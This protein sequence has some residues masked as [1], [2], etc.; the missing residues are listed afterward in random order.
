MR[1]F[2]KDDRYSVTVSTGESLALEM[3]VFD[4]ALQMFG[5]RH[6]S[7]VMAPHGG[8]EFVTSD[9]PL[10]VVF[11]DSKARGP[12]GY[13]LPGTEV[14]FPVGARHVLLGVFE[15]PLARQIDATA[16][17]VAAINSRTVHHADRQ[18]YSR[19]EA[20]TI[21]RNDGIGNLDLERSNKRM[22]PT[23]RREAARSLW[24]ERSPP[25]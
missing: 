22:E 14:T 7:L 25:L 15:D 18:I 24:D 21:L 11:K 16:G 20:V 12:I 19:T 13:G 4:S 1:R 3:S 6:W 8:P 9:H 5:T 17:Q 2:L 10:G 23:V